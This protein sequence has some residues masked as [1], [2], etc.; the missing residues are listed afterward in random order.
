MRKYYLS[1]SQCRELLPAL[2]RMKMRTILLACIV[3]LLAWGTAFAQSTEFTYQGKL[4]DGGLAPT[5]TYDIEF[6]LWDVG[7][8][9]TT[10]LATQ[11]VP[12]VQ[13]R[14]GIFTVQL[15][16]GA[17]FPGAQRWIEIAVK[18]PADATFTTLTP[19]QMVTNAPYSVR[20][21]VSTTADSAD[22][23]SP[24][25]N[26]C[27]TDAQ[28]Q[29]VDGT[30]VT[31]VVAIA[32]GGTGSPTQNFVDL[33]GDQE[34]TGNKTFTG[35]TL[36]AQND[37][38]A[39]SIDATNLNVSNAVVNGNLGIGTNNPAGKLHID[40]PGSQT[41]INALTVDVGSFG[42]PANAVNS[43]YFRT[44]DIGSGSPPAFLIRGDGRVGIGTASP[45]QNLEVVGN[46]NVTG[47]FTSRVDAPAFHIGGNR[48]LAGGGS[49]NFS[50]YVGDGAGSANPTGQYNTF[51]GKNTG[52]VVSN[53][54]DNTFVGSAAA[55]KA[56]GS[57]NTFMGRLAGLNIEAGDENVFLGYLAGRNFISGSGNIAI[58]SRSA[59]QCVAANGTGSNNIYIGTGFG[60][61]CTDGG[62]SNSI[63]IGNFA[64]QSNEIRIGNTTQPLSIGNFSVSSAGVVKIYGLGAGGGSTL[65][66]N[67]LSEIAFC[68]SSI[69]Y[70]RN[71]HSFVSG[72]ELVNRLRPVT[73]DWKSDGKADMGLVAEEV[74]EVEPLLVTHNE[75]GE[76]EGVKYDRIGVVLINAVK[77]QQAQIEELKKQLES[78]QAAIDALKRL[79]PTQATSQTVCKD[80]K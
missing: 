28:I 55:I 69:R 10:P 32:N 4:L 57:Y 9:G 51:V 23:L 3:L 59:N 31:G 63:A 46:V 6:R 22:S 19:R 56:T 36:S 77:E 70:K 80:V 47:S 38:N 15:D 41:P 79:L 74:A 54:S 34:I 65:C 16:L 39:T 33:T 48:F 18:K 14:N 1:K 66:R 25:C 71:I 58:G 62:I 5:A 42:T 27:V 45:S 61:A 17:N 11:T 75:K 37:F 7:A 53:G 68:S 40:V 67:S 78:Q 60:G 50:T 30:K 52:F 26:L 29:A 2:R 8:G 21:L 64:L 73:Y 43:Y 20:S 24:V 49:F 44:R 35:N 12:A 76:V 72:L 13:V